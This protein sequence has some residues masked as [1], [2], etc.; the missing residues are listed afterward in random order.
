MSNYFRDE[1][2]T[3][4]DHVI[5]HY[6]KSKSFDYKSSVIGEF[7]AINNDNKADRDGI[8]I[9]VPLKHLSDIWRILKYH[10][11]IVK[12]PCVWLGLKVA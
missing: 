6:L 11:L 4:D 12:Y 10:W 9:V 1:T 2:T 5:N 3:D 7:W 8:K